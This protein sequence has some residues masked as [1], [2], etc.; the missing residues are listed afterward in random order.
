MAQRARS[1]YGWRGRELLAAPRRR[2]GRDGGRDGYEAQV[3]ALLSGG[4]AVPRVTAVSAR[5]VGAHRS[6]TGAGDEVASTRRHAFRASPRGLAGNTHRWEVR[7]STTRAA[8]RGGKPERKGLG[9]GLVV[10]HPRGG[11]RFTCGT[12]V[13]RSVGAASPA[14]S[15]G[16]PGPPSR[17]S[18]WAANDG[19]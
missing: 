6:S 10:V 7:S 8:V 19:P 13:A 4:P 12:V 15:S 9:H 3:D 11:Q 18:R 14:D 1:S 16:G 2:H 17:R 5:R